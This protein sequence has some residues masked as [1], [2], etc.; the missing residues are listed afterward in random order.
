MS[1]IESTIDPYATTGS[2]TRSEAEPQPLC[3]WPGCEDRATMHPANGQ[4]CYDAL[5]RDLVRPGRKPGQSEQTSDRV[6]WGR[7]VCQ[8]GPAHLRTH[9]HTQ[10]EETA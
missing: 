1:S 8:P 3:D 2:L 7:R 4:W 10:T 5:P 9:P 6:R